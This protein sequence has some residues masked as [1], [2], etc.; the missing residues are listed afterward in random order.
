MS[1]KKTVCFYLKKKKLE[2]CHLVDG[3]KN[4]RGE[5]QKG[6]DYSHLL[7]ARRTAT[8]SQAL[9]GNKVHPKGSVTRQ[10]GPWDRRSI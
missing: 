7:Y 6:G 10:E 2:G 4:V 3:V 5:V 1:I 9:F 8:D